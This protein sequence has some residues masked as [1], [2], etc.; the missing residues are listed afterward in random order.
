MRRETTPT[1]ELADALRARWSGSGDPRLEA[2]ARGETVLLGLDELPDEHRPQRP[3]PCRGYRDD[4]ELW[5]DGEFRPSLAYWRRR[6]EAP[7]PGPKRGPD[8]TAASNP[9]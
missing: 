8:L 3:D 4:F 9:I 1:L 7:L 5:P 6:L 2:L